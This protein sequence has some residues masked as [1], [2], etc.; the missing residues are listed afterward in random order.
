MKLKKIFQSKIKKKKLLKILI[1]KQK[2]ISMTKNKNKFFKSIKISIIFKN[3]KN[4]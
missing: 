3:K 4:Y 1:N 2:D